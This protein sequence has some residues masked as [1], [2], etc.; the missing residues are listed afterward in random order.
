V[1]AINCA[2]FHHFPLQ[3]HIWQMRIMVAPQVINEINHELKVSGAHH[4]GIQVQDKLLLTC[5][6]LFSAS[7]PTYLLSGSSVCFPA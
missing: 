1:L 4:D 5:L 2:A 3:A 6:L 7:M